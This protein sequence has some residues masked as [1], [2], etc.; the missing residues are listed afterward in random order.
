MQTPSTVP[1]YQPIFFSFEFT[2]ILRSIQQG[3]DTVATQAAVL[4]QSGSIERSFRVKMKRHVLV[5]LFCS[6]VRPHTGKLSTGS[7]NQNTFVSRNSSQLST[8]ELLRSSSLSNPYQTTPLKTV[9]QKLEHAMYH[10][11][12]NSAVYPSFESTERGFHTTVDNLCSLGG[13]SSHRLS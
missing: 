7:R 6:A 2:F 9:H 11:K 3:R 8:F 10:R 1:V 4:G 12:P 13:S 5:P